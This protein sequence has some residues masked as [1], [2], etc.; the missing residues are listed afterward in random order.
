MGFYFMGPV[1]VPDYPPQRLVR[2][3]VPNRAH[4]SDRPLLI[5]FDGQNVFDDAPSFAGGWRAH[6]RV[7]KLAKKVSP[8]VVVGIDHGGG[9]RIEEL[10]PFPMGRSHGRLDGF[11]DWIKRWLI[12]HMQHH[13]AVTHDPRKIV[14]GGSSMG[15]IAALYGLLSLPHVFGGCIA[16]SPSLWIARARIFQWA[17]SRPAPEHARIYIDAGKREPP[18]MHTQADAMDKVL[19]RQGARNLHFFS[20]PTGTHSEAAWRKR[21]PR[22]LRFQFG[23]AKKAAY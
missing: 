15:G 14:L 16:M 10:S 7:E 2:I 4:A 11:L 6:E 9:H 12:P 13:F 17:E 19:Y 21:L 23:S 8:P 3:Y 1:D 5:L 20:D 18:T 22:A